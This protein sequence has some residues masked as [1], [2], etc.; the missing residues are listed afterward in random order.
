MRWRKH[1]RRVFALIEAVENSNIV[2]DEVA[3]PR[4]SRW[5][6]GLLAFS[7][8]PSPAFG[9]VREV[10]SDR[11]MVLE[12]CHRTP[13]VRGSSNARLK[14]LWILDEWNGGSLDHGNR[15][16]GLLVLTGGRPRTLLEMLP[17]ARPYLGDGLFHQPNG[18]FGD[19]L[20]ADL[21]NLDP[22]IP[23][24]AFLRLLRRPDPGEDP[25]ERITALIADPNVPTLSKERI[26]EVIMTEPNIATEQEQLI[27]TARLR[28]EGRREGLREGL[29]E[30]HRE[31]LREGRRE[32]LLQLAANVVPRVDLDSL[33]ELSD[34]ELYQRVTQLMR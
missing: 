23:G 5:I 8:Q 6:D 19:I 26:R 14:H 33:R 10:L 34:E 24:A 11:L 31:G 18:R 30:G 17:G 2:Q 20:I 3:V 27:I 32:M 22:S 4:S 13:G 21:K 15:P 1:Q 28:E 7:P 16:P 12:H 9:L 29:R 25:L